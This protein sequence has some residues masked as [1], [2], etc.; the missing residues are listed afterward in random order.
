MQSGGPS[1]LHSIPATRDA[2][3][4]ANGTTTTTTNGVNGHANGDTNGTIT[5]GTTNGTSNGTARRAKICVYCGA[6]PGFK[7]QHMEAARELATYMAKNNIDLVYG[8]GTV[9]L[10]GEVAK[11]LV[12]LAGPDSVH[13]IIPEALVKWERDDTYGT[14]N[15]DNMFVPD[16][17]VYGRTTVVKDMHTRKQMMAKEVFAGGPGS[18]FIALPGGYGTIEEVLE[19]ATWNQLGIHDKGICLL[20]INGFYDGILEWV[21]K[22]V[23]EGFIKAANADILVTATTAE[24][25]INAL[26]YYKVS[27][28]TFKLDWSNS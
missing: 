16:E 20:N 17:S 8:G 22:S 9:G 11:T 23:D 4:S 6:S 1:P 18:G 28:A 27:E 7:P 21:H 14:L 25:A 3:P 12:S 2:T 10:M 24:G 26:R 15:K 19:T 13:G 5:N